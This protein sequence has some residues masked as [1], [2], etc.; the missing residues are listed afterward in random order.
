M[1]LLGLALWMALSVPTA[2]REARSFTFLIDNFLKTVVIFG[3]IAGAV[4]NWKD[5]E[6]LAL[7]YFFGAAVYAAAV[8]ARFEVGPESWRLNELY[9]YD[10]NDFA[11][12]AVTALPFGL[13][14]LTRPGSHLRRYSAIIGCVTIGVALDRKSVV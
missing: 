2:L 10:P 12:Y 14:A 8:I 6:R 7:T 13:Y 9:T 1:F 3:L 5:I 11:T 4:R